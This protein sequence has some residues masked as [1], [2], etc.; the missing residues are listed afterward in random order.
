[1]NIEFPLYIV[2]QRA[3][4]NMKDRQLWV[5]VLMIW[6]IRTSSSLTKKMISW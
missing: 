2:K 5:I 1:M 6:Y 3:K 4:E